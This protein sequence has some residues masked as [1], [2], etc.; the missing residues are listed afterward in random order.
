MAT[1]S[2][3]MQSRAGTILQRIREAVRPL[4]LSSF[5]FVVVMQL[6]YQQSVDGVRR[7]D[8]GAAGKG[9]EGAFDGCAAFHKGLMLRGSVYLIL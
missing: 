5:Y 3:S 6:L 4:L 7:Q 9:C 1:L 2:Q 8:G